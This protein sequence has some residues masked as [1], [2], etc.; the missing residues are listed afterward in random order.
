MGGHLSLSDVPACRLRSCDLTIRFELMP[1]QLTGR[2]LI[3]IRIRLDL[4]R[5]S[6]LWGHAM[7]AHTTLM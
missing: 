5:S 6:G 2:M 1:A 7:R 4:A 3:R